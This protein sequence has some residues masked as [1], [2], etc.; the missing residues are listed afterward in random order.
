MRPL[1]ILNISAI[2][3]S[4]INAFG[5]QIPIIKQSIA[6]S[7]KNAGDIPAA[8][9]EYRRQYSINP[10]NYENTYNYACALSINRQI[11]S[12]FKYLNLAI[13]LDTSI[14]A[15]IDPDFLTIREDKRWTQFENNLISIL[16]KKLNNPWKDIEYAKL[17]WRMRA[18][19][20]AYATDIGIAGTKIGWKSSVV[21]ALWASKFRI[22]KW[23]QKELDELI[24]K[25]GWPRVEN[26]GSEAAFTAWL[27]VMHSNSEYI[28][29]YLPTIKKICEEKE[30]SWERY[31]SIYDRSLWF[32]RKPQKY[33][34][35]TQFN[36]TTK[37]EE[38]YPLEDE[39]KVDEWRKEL[40]LQPLKEYLKQFNIQYQ[41][42][43]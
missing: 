10:K 39:S 18:L 22:G 14:S 29:K 28:Q 13:K 33:G 8:I 27:I 16:N 7:L 17:L 5:Q 21:E 31:V 40:G 20:Q 12:S 15:L 2:T 6:D 25:K 42:K 32:D 38:L 35:H 24:A 3:L 37:K 36:E 43:N 23:N 30:L 4:A 1:N 26:V 41:S 19:D 9:V 11:D 34:T